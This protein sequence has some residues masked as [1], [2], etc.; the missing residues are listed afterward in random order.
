MALIGDVV[1][2]SNV[3]VSG[4]MDPYEH[5]G[6]FFGEGAVSTLRSDLV[7]VAIFENVLW[8]CA[9]PLVSSYCLVLSVES[10]VD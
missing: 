5:L 7:S 2:V 10:Q 4:N 9:F 3:E 8:I 1:S 6:S